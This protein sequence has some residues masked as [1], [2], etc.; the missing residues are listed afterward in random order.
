M[1]LLAISIDTDADSFKRTLSAFQAKQLPF[2]SSQAV[3]RLARRAITDLQSEMRKVF[4]NPTNYTLKAFFQHGGTK[5][6]PGAEI[7]ARENAGK[8]T[9]GWKYLTPEVFGGTRNMKRFERALAAHFGSGFSVPGRGAQLNAFGNISP[10][11][12]EKLLSALGAA[13]SRAGYRANR[14][15]L[16][17]RQRRSLG[18]SGDY[19]HGQFFIA[20]AKDDGS[21]L[22][23]YQIVGPG[24]VV[25]V[26]IFPHRQPE[27]RKRLRYA[28]TIQ[29]SV[30]DHAGPFLTEELK[31]AIA[32]SKPKA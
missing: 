22:G 28:E 15:N 3:N 4:D 16:S 19:R 11:F 8:G 31:K 27:Y 29:K 10:G 25:P 23:I 2:A 24:R 30:A 21:L 17:R 12:V 9:P 13:E 20:H 5:E 6:N 18:A 1:P 26:L 14:R 32:T 7:R